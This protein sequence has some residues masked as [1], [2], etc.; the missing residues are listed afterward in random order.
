[1]C[2]SRSALNRDLESCHVVYL[3]FDLVLWSAVI[4]INDPNPVG[5]DQSAPRGSPATESN[6]QHKTVGDGNDDVAG[7]Q[8]RAVRRHVRVCPAHKIEARRSR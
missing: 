3:D 8:S 4:P 6:N 1:M 7:Y 5:H 2:D